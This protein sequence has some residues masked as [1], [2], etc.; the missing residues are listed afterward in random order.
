MPTAAAVAAAADKMLLYIWQH[1]I[2][3]KCERMAMP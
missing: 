1:A 3:I 2:M